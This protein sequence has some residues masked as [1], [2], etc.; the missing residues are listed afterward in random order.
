MSLGIALFGGIMWEMTSLSQAVGYMTGLLECSYK[1]PQYKG[2]SPSE[3][4]IWEL[5][6][7]SFLVLAYGTNTG[8]VSHSFIHYM[9]LYSASS[10]LLLRSAPDFSTAKK[11]SFK[12]GVEC[13]RVN[14]GGN[15]SATGS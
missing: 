10:R 3:M 1:F 9:D 12:A 2:F 11:S 15:R 6:T 7:M 14:P 4:S 13:V 5:Y 8:Y